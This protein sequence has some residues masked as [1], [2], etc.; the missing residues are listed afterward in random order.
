MCSG[1]RR[2]FTETR[3]ITDIMTSFPGRQNKTTWLDEEYNVINAHGGG[4]LPFD[5]GYYWYGEH[6]TEGWEGRLA[7]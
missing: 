7:P 1:N 3:T 6:K 5:G 4:I 2:G